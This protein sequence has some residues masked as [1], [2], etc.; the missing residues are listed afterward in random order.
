MPASRHLIDRARVLLLLG[1]LALSGLFAYLAV[2]KVRWTEVWDALQ[3]S[4]YWWLVPALLLLICANVVRADRWQSMFAPETRPAFGPTL[5]AMLVGQ[6]FNNIL[7]ARAGEAARVIV[8]HRRA[9]A[10]RAETT[11]TVVL[12]R[13]F[14]VLALLVLLFIVLPWFPKVSW[15]LAAALLAIG[16][17]VALTLLVVMLAR[18]GERPLLLAFRPLRLLPF[19]PTELIE[20]AAAHLAR[21]LTSIRRPG[22]AARATFWTLG[23]WLLIAASNWTLMRGFDLG[24]SVAAGLLVAITT[25]LGMIIPSAPGAIGVYEAATLVALGAYGVPNS[26]AFSY[27]LVL[28]AMNLLPYLVA[29]AVVLRLDRWLRRRH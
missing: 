13:A 10:S 19:V 23:S 9:A 25:G 27:A 29:G 8:L 4:S 26:R 7:P 15:L 14:D 11:A 16:L 21:G 28:H 3:T 2:R 17:T 6:F 20:R 12:E 22:V 24:L 18:F 5:E 1:G